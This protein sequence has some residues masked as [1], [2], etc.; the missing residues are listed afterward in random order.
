MVNR[1]YVCF[2][3]A[4]DDT[5]Q[6]ITK[7][8]RRYDPKYFHCYKSYVTKDVKEQQIQTHAN[9]LRHPVFF[10]IP[11]VIIATLFFLVRAGKHHGFIGKAEAKTKNEIIIPAENAGLI[12]LDN[13]KKKEAVTPAIADIPVVPVVRNAPL[14]HRQK[15]ISKN[16][17]DEPYAVINGKKIGYCEGVICVE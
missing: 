7:L 3:Y 6:P 2:A 16:K 12:P 17:I 10:A 4:G 9:I 14:V 8:V 13:E 11:I 1:S 15:V 5:G